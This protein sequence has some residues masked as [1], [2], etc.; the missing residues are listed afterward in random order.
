MRLL[1]LLSLF[2]VVVAAR[3]ATVIYPIEAIEDLWNLPADEFR[4]NLWAMP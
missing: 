3:A 4:Q 1:R 2:A